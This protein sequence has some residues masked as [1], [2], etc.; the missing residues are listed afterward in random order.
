MEV[1]DGCARETVAAGGPVRRSPFTHCLIKYPR[2]Y[3]GL[4]HCFLITVI[5]AELNFVLDNQQLWTLSVQIPP[6]SGAKAHLGFATLIIVEAMIEVVADVFFSP[7]H[8][9]IILRGHWS[10]I[11][12]GFCY[13]AK[14]S[15]ETIHDSFK[16]QILNS[17]P[18]ASASHETVLA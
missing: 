14:R 15:L 18:R 13:L 3:A 4:S 11:K 17:L 12:V 7:G 16:P 6:T 1:L 10:F 8:R 9:M 2:S 5:Q